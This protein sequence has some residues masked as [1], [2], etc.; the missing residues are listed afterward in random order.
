MGGGGQDGT[1]LSA[2]LRARGDQVAILKRGD[3][4]IDNP[5]S[6][7]SCIGQVLPDEVY[8]L[9]A[10]HQSSEES[11][12]DD[13]ELFLTSTQV[14]FT[15]AVNFLAALARQRPNAR[16]FYAASSLIFGASDGRLQDEH[17][18][19]RPQTAYGITKLA[20]LLACRRYREIHGLHASVGIL[21][22]HESSLRPT[23][24]LSR[25]IAVAVARIART[26]QGELALG[27]LDARV[28]WGYAPDYVDAMI[29][30]V[31]QDLPDE[32]IVASGEAHS[33]REFAEHAF[34][35]VG[36]DY[37]SHVRAA[38]NLLHRRLPPRVGSPN[39][40]MA[41]TGWR[42]SVDFATMVRLM[43][44]AELAAEEATGHESDPS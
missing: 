41:A 17:T 28:D 36:L 32:Y 43:V 3:L 30:I 37:R 20:G 31:A 2:A 19:P 16:F 14:N 40:L 11:I 9:A 25:K 29:R 44:N 33:V 4:E 34:S 8:F 13:G 1:L 6:V 42:P 23:S 7:A 26:G 12:I 24:F 15:S 38:P 21:Y 27:D 5:A 39:K 35:V 18:P 10:H 22:N